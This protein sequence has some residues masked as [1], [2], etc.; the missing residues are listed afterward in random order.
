VHGA[1]SSVSL[2]SYFPSGHA[3]H[4]VFSA[5]AIEPAP[6]SLHDVCPSL[7]WTHPIGHGVQAVTIPAV[8]YVPASQSLFV[9]APPDAGHLDPP[10]HSV[11]SAFVAVPASS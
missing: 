9:V 10:E 5:F 1:H 7:G 8:E 6:H 2:D 11:H 4:V 3:E